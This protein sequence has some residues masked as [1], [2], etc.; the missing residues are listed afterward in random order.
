MDL[1]FV[2]NLSSEGVADMFVFDQ[3]GGPDGISGSQFASEMQ[4]IKEVEGASEINVF[5]NSPG[6][7]VQD[8]LSILTAIQRFE[9]NTIIAGIAAS[10]AGVISQ[11]GKTRKM[12]D[13]GRLMIH[14]PFYA[15]QQQNQTL[16]DRDKEALS[17]I[18]DMLANILSNNSKLNKKDIQSLMFNE[19]WIDAER[20]LNY[21]MIDE[22]I[23]TDREVGVIK[24]LE[25]MGE[26]VEANHSIIMQVAAQ[27][28]NEIK[29]INL[30]PLTMTK[31]ANY[32]NLQEAANEGQIVDA[33]KSIEND[34]EVKT[35]ELETVTK[36][37]DEK[38]ARIAELERE[39]AALKEKAAEAF[40][41]DVEA[42]LN[43]A[44]ENG[45][46]D[47]EKKESLLPEALNNFDLFKTVTESITPK[48]AHVDIT[49]SIDT[50][51]GATE[52][53]GKYNGMTFDELSKKDPKA[54]NTLRTENPEKFQELF[55]AQYKKS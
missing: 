30:K 22:I 40:N 51:V 27:L 11:A 41:K 44:I 9:A 8:A 1:Q 32:L 2:K 24:K 43:N 52:A 3:I 18:G 34:L 14:L 53:E 48:G 54:L 31:V 47:K 28:N 19:T 20:A 36:S 5:I 50:S 17:H 35:A 37:V 13:F 55:N 39:N 42:F 6:G 10:S 26:D 21:G 16:T 29:Q 15:N 12:V 49:D 23:S 33:I 46:Y 7:L 4:F 25:E 45:I 38:D